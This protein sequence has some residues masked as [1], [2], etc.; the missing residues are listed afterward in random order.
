MSE[1]QRRLEALL[2][3][4]LLDSEPAESLER[5]IR[6]AQL[7]LGVPVV[8]ISL[9]DDNRQFFAN[10]VGLPAPW[11][12][13]RETPLSHS[14]CKHVVERRAPLVVADA[15]SD[16]V[17]K[18][19]LA[20]RDLGVLAYAGMP[21][22][23]DD[24]QTLGSFCAIDGKPHQWTDRELALLKDLAASVSAEIDL[25]RRMRRAEASERVLAELN[26]N[27]VQGRNRLAESDRTFRHDLRSPLQVIQLG[28]TTL[29]RSGDF[30]NSPQL[31]R[32]LAL[33]EKNV[34]HAASILNFM[35]DPEVQF[36]SPVSA[37]EAVEEA[38]QT[39]RGLGSSIAVNQLRNDAVSIRINPTNL[40]RCIENLLSNSVRFAHSRIDVAL[41]RDGLGASLTVEDDGP[42][43]PSQSAYIDVW[44]SGKTYHHHQGLSGT[45]L[46]LN[47]V[48]EIV[49]RAGGTVSASI[50]VLG[51]ARFR[52]WF[53][54]VPE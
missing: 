3:T 49:E 38:I 46:G 33:I 6:I 44:T 50:S 48:Q 13:K 15:P 40:R 52:L 5:F 31:A 7:A 42:G 22:T 28:I 23:T 11:A 54:I 10:S 20:I 12:E 9:V 29:L 21:I 8:L 16:P 51:G 24:S 4:G 25:R 27:L 19:N 45:G 2:E 18:D 36:E 34:A 17:V 43:L 1:E 41:V 39:Y 53:P 26:N 47:I 37:N 14:F 35:K 30:R 32:S